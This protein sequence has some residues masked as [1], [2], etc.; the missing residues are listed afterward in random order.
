M[1]VVIDVATVLLLPLLADATTTACAAWKTLKRWC[2]VSYGHMQLK[3][4]R[5][6]FRCTATVTIISV[7]VRYRSAASSHRCNALQ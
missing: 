7:L 1:K 5:S 2:M 6:I 4:T 3:F